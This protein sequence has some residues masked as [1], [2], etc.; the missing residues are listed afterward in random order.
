MD[1][2]KGQRGIIVEESFDEGGCSADAGELSH[3]SLVIIRN[4][5]CGR[6]MNGWTDEKGYARC[7]D[8]LIR[9]PTKVIHAL[10]SQD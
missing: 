6:H 10:C 5:L 1:H 4:E 3:D 8:F 2:F 7:I 9:V